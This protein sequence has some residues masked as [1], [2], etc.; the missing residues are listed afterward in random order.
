MIALAVICATL[1]ALGMIGLA[2]G[3]RRDRAAARAL[4]SGDVS[5]AL[6]FCYAEVQAVA[7]TAA[8]RAGL[9]ISAEVVDE[10]ALHAIDD[11]NRGLLPVDEL[12][13]RLSR[14]RLRSV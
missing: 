11:L 10:V 8:E 9:G 5:P 3:W 7:I 14:R 13:A 12:A 2:D 4:E 6:G 1:V